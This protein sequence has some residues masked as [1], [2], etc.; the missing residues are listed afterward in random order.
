MT[1]PGTEVVG[2]MIDGIKKGN[3]GLGL[4]SAI[5]RCGEILTGPFPIAGID[6]NELRDYLI[7][8]E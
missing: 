4:A 1:K 8:K 2:I 3:V 7:I 6:V 5:K